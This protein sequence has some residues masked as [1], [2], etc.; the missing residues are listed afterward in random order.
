MVKRKNLQPRTLY[1]AR[2]SFTFDREI[3]SLQTKKSA[4]PNSFTTGSKGTSLG[5]KGKKVHQKGK[6]T[7]K[8]RNHLHTNMI[9]KSVVRGGEYKCKIAEVHT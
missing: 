9:P 8:R 4:P 5:G 1:P 7:V 6:H 2:F 3:K